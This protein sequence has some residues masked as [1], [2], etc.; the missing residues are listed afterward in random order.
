[1][2]VCRTIKGDIEIKKLGFCQ[3]HEHLFVREGIPSQINQALKIEDY[4]K[5]LEE[6]STYKKNGG[7]SLV[8]AQPIGTGRMA[9]WLSKIVEE[10]NVNII[11]STG[12]H[13]LSFYDDEHWIKNCTIK[14]YKE[15]LNKEINI[16]MYENDIGS[17]LLLGKKAGMIKTAYIV[18]DQEKRYRE[19]LKASAK[20]AK[21]TGIPLMCHTD[22]GENSLEA[23]KI[24][25]DSGISP[26]SVIICHLDRKLDN[27]DTHMKVAET[28]VMLDYDTIGRFKYHNDEEE[29][30]LIKKM[31]KKRFVNNLVL[32]LDTTR[33]RLKTYG[34]EIG[35]SYIINTFIPQMK[36]KGISQKEI[37]IMM[38]KN[39]RKV[40]KIKKRS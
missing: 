1:M 40:L 21:K 22:Y 33:E 28:G 5:T 26:S 24:I 34:A 27:F 31:L 23:I 13:K 8:D 16:G 15:V 25:L 14:K 9:N 20:V 18:N 3:C 39:P 17:N 37:E 36:R 32:S 30:K 19:L 4:D 12:F 6:V 7:D 29:I 35:L 10:I 11:A 38:I 2:E